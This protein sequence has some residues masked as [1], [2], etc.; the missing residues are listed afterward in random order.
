MGFLNF[1]KKS[2][3]A[4]ASSQDDAGLSIPP[5]PPFPQ[6]AATQRDMPPSTFQGDLPDFKPFGQEIE[7]PALS[8]PEMPEAHE[9]KDF[10]AP[11]PVI[12]GVPPPAPFTKQNVPKFE[13]P[14]FKV[15]DAHDQDYLEE[16]VEEPREEPRD[17]PDPELSLGGAVPQIEPQISPIPEVKKP[18]ISIP[19]LREQPIERPIRV[20]HGI[21]FIKAPHVASLANDLGR[22]AE[23]LRRMT[24]KIKQV[25]EQERVTEEWR[26][27]LEGLYRKLLAAE[28]AIFAGEQ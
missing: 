11:T 5:P 17:E 13:P 8:L 1:L 9:T 7:A 3:P 18:E 6:T 15:E 16:P 23:R 25:E 14:E 19:Q 10:I 20:Q 26:Q 22:S 24:V 21:V 12:S 28:K 2:K 4:L 27:D